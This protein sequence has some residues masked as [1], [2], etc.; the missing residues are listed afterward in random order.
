METTIQPLTDEQ[1]TNIKRLAEAMR[2]GAKLR[3]Q[4]TGVLFR[5][6]CL[7]DGGER[8]I[9][10]CALGAAWEGSHP[11]FNPKHWLEESVKIDG[12]TIGLS[13]VERYFGLVSRIECINP[14]KGWKHEIVGTIIDLNDQ[15]DWTREQIAD[16]LDTLANS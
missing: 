16:W 14:A 11:A 12:E 13:D 10:S 15:C 3:P 9:C 2:E 5:T 1:K 7:E 8:Q 6:L 4:A